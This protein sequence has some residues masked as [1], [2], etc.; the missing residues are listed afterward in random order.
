MPP[1][2]VIIVSDY[3]GVSFFFRAGFFGGNFLG[4]LLVSGLS[5]C[6]SEG[7]TSYLAESEPALPIGATFV[8]VTQRNHHTSC[9]ADPWK[10]ILMLKRSFGLAQPS[11]LG[12]FIA[13][14]LS[15]SGSF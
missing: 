12:L 2:W 3:V 4:A 15:L 1:D 13:V 14:W 10:R 9:R 5:P 11:T 8:R 7:W 6:A